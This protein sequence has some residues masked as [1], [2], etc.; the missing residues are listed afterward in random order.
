MESLKIK[1]LLY[2]DFDEN[3]FLNIL[4]VKKANVTSLKVEAKLQLAEDKKLNL[5]HSRKVFVYFTF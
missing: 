2:N 3:K 1:C 5:Q 4:E